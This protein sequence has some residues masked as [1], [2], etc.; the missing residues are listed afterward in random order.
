MECMIQLGYSYELWLGLSGLYKDCSFYSR[1]ILFIFGVNTCEVIIEGGLY[2]SE[3]SDG[4]NKVKGNKV[5]SLQI[6]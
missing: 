4:G 3:G 6:L 5:E 1:G 2:S